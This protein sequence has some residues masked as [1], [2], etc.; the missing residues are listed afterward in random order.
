[1]I[2]TS[3]ILNAC[4]LPI[5]EQEGP[6]DR[7]CLPRST[8]MVLSLQLLKLWPYTPYCDCFFRCFET[9]GCWNPCRFNVVGE[10]HGLLASFSATQN[11]FANIVSLSCWALQRFMGKG[12]VGSK[13]SGLMCCGSCSDISPKLHFAMHLPVQLRK[14]G[15]LLSCWAQERRHKEVKRQPNHLDTGSAGIER[16]LLPFTL[17]LLRKLRHGFECEMERCPSNS[18]QAVL[19]PFWTAV[20]SVTIGG[21]H[22]VKQGEGWRCGASVRTE[23]SGWSV[24][25]FEVSGSLVDRGCSLRQAAWHQ[26][27]QSCEGAHV[28][29]CYWRHSWSMCVQTRWRQSNHSIGDV[30]AESESVK[31]G[32]MFVPDVFWWKFVFPLFWPCNSMLG[33]ARW[34]WLHG[35]CSQTLYLLDGI[36]SHPVYINSLT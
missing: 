3:F 27:L 23:C 32:A 22:L 21:S 5:C 12:C 28:V 31:M 25:P 33:F 9:G 4:G 2:F 7:P 10:D 34:K 8:K 16:S 19:W 35:P 17:V 20:A 26:H 30:L 11:E 18:C 15:V 1:M 13:F 29:R 36:V 6:L 24:S 14:H